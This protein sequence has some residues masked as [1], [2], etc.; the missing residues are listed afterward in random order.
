MAFVLP[1]RYWEDQATAPAPLDDQVVLAGRGGG[2]LEASDTLAV[3]WFGGFAGS[4]TVR[5]KTAALLEAVR[6][7]GE[8]A[9]VDEEREPLLMQYN[10]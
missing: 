4:E 8:W 9:L 7:D 3:L 1:S 2:V 10:D 5:E 6:A